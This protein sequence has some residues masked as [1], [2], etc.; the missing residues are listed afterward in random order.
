MF[1]RDC[2]NAMG[3]MKKKVRKKNATAITSLLSVS[4]T[5]GIAR[6]SQYT[7]RGSGAHPVNHIVG[8][9][10]CCVCA[11]TA[12]PHRVLK[13]T[14]AAGMIDLGLFTILSLS[15]EI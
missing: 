4:E 11:Q 15:K 12:A 3:I 2:T 14:N 10:D 7:S 13:E 1:A 9:L 5:N 8:F 6:L